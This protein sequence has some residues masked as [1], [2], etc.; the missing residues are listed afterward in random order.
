[1][2]YKVII[3][4]NSSAGR[5]YEIDSKSAMKAAQEFGRCEGGEVVTVTS[6]SG[7]ELSRVIW[8]PENGG[9]YI[10]VAI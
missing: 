6:K 8:T 5:E 2:K 4:S 10:R 7:R 3:T 1:M 9:A